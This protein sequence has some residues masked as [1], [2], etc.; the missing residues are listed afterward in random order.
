M[1]SKV[2]SFDFKS[3]ILTVKTLQVFR[4]SLIIFGQFLMEEVFERNPQNNRRKIPMIV[5]ALKMFFLFLLSKSDT[6]L[7]C[8]GNPSLAT[9]FLD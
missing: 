4:F 1:W 3:S 2:K 9:F 8:N 7:P 6:N 5:A